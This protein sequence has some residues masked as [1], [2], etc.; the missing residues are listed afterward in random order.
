MKLHITNGD[1]TGEMLNDSPQITGEVL[2]WRD[3]LHDGPVQSLPY[4]AYVST[5]TTYLMALLERGE[6]SGDINE[7]AI[8]A[9]FMA[10]KEVLDRI[11]Q[12]DEVVLWFEHDL[13]DQLQL[14]EICHRL[15]A[16]DVALPPLSLICI[17]HHPEV[18]F[19]HGL[20]NLTLEMMNDLFHQRTSL[21]RA[22]VDRAASL[23]P[24]LTAPSPEPL[25]VMAQKEI[26]GWP[27]MADALRRFCLE[28]PSLETG[29]TLTQTYLLLTLLK[30]PDEL[31]A[32]AHHLTGA[33]QSGRLPDGVSAEQRYYEIL[34]GPARFKRIF[35][36]LQ[37]LEVA[38]FM[39][40]LSVRYELNRLLHAA[41]PYIAK[42]LVNNEAVYSLTT[43]GAEALQMRRQWQSVNTMDLWR[44]GVHITSDQ[45]WLWDQRNACF[46][47]ET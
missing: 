6:Y 41:T 43:A 1:C 40:D 35:H 47:I 14:I 46:C 32:L 19:F 4:D 12:Y 20:G 39:G 13:Y 42:R 29:L 23:W 33:E 36:H 7:Q 8:M 9:D 34:T 45:C 15:L 5:R 44:G 3:L 31:P 25:A 2:C 37:A 27:F 18:P 28:Y 17:N 38:P 11:A 16:S 21:S 10:R 24:L 22:Q 26:P 30:A